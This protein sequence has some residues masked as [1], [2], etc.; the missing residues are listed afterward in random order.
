MHDFQIEYTGGRDPQTEELQPWAVCES[1]G[2]DIYPGDEYRELEDGAILCT[3][4]ECLVSATGAF[5]KEAI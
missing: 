4:Y 5:I 3:D 1:C 2:C